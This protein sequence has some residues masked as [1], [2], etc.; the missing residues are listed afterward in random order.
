MTEDRTH[1]LGRG[2]PTVF[3][4]R[5]QATIVSTGEEMERCALPVAL[6]P[7][8]AAES[9]QMSELGEAMKALAA[10]AAATQT[11]LVE[12]RRGR[13]SDTICYNCGESGHHAVACKEPKREARK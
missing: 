4:A 6:A 7:K 11:E 8:R 5:I 3:D 12:M 2:F 10:M 9:Q 13:G 1:D